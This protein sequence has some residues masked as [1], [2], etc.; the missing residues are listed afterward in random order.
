MVQKDECAGA[1]A[2]GVIDAAEPKTVDFGAVE[3]QDASDLIR[4]HK[5][6]VEPACGCRHVKPLQP[7]RTPKQAA[8]RTEG[9][10]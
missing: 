3:Q 8:D 9:H 4:R 7:K 2:V 6:P 5:Q 1:Q 10:A